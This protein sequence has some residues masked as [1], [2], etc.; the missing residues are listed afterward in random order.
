MENLSTSDDKSFILK[1]SYCMDKVHSNRDKYTNNQCIVNVLFGS[2]S[3][4]T[5]GFLI[6]LMYIFIRKKC[7]K[8]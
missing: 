5:V 1:W 8:K 2:I 6:L 4:I 3:F 7:V